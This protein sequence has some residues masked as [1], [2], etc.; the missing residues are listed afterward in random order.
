MEEKFSEQLDTLNGIT[1]SFEPEVAEHNAR[2]KQIQEDNR[3]I[4]NLQ[5]NIKKCN[6][7]LKISNDKNNLLEIELKNLMWRLII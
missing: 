5:D 3:C 2:V 7:D 6:A 1:S 4:K